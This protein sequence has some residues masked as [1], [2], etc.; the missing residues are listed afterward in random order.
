MSKCLKCKVEVLDETEICPLCRS[1]LEQT[2]ELENMYPDARFKTRKLLFVSRLYLF[3]AVVAELVL[4]GVDFK[5]QTEFRWSVVI[6]LGLLYIYLVLRFAG[7]GEWGHK[8]KTLVFVL[9][10]VLTA[11][12]IDFATGYRGWSVDYVLSSGILLVDVCIIVMMIC[13]HRNWQS[14]IMWQILMILLSLIPMCLYLFGIEKF[15]ELA[16]LPLIVSLL[17]LLGTLM[18]G[19][20]RAW[21]EL[22]RRF[23]I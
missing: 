13:N 7:I 9:F 16:F 2:E 19:G 18:I 22:K 21:L 5:V 17:L 4:L 11:V 8:S 3:C 1:V 10:A 6:G 12:G 23:H 15:G 20:R 14:Y